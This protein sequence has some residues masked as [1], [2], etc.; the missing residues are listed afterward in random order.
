MPNAD[1]ST[2]YFLAYSLDSCHMLLAPL[3]AGGK[4]SVVRA[5]GGNT[6]DEDEDE[7]LETVRRSEKKKAGGRQ[8]C[9]RKACTR[10]AL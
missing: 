2:L 3:A 10:S 4:M 1:M 7:E 8:V 5:E 6:E 9:S